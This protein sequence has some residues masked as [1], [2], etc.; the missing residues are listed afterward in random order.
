[1]FGALPPFDSEMNLN[2]RILNQHEL[3]YLGS[4]KT[5]GYMYSAYQAY[6]HRLNHFL[7]VPVLSSF[8]LH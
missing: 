1:M 6:P 8:Y 7:G 4:L 3:R 5:K 2:L